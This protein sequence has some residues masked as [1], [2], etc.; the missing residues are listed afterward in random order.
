M[1]TSLDFL[2]R[3]VNVHFGGEGFYLVLTITATVYDDT[4]D[5]PPP[6]PT[7]TLTLPKG[8]TRLDTRTEIS[9]TSTPP[10]DIPVAPKYFIWSSMAP[11]PTQ[12]NW[13]LVIMNN[14]IGGVI[15]ASQF[16]YGGDFGAGWGFI[17]GRESDINNGFSS[18]DD[19]FAQYQADIIAIDPTHIKS[20]TA[21]INT[22]GGLI[23]VGSG[24]SYESNTI[25]E[26]TFDPIHVPGNASTTIVAT[27]LLTSETNDK[28]KTQV[29]ISGLYSPLPT[30]LSASVYRREVLGEITKL[31][32]VT[33]SP[34]ASDGGGGNI[35]RY[36]VT[37]GVDAGTDRATVTVTISDSGGGGGGGGE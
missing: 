33:G 37:A 2:S 30:D 35:D 20:Y 22:S 12:E 19:A 10:H 27:Y 13:D 15:Y 4:T 34:D 7:V 14:N 5:V 6:A 36:D 21:Y 9:T 8:V 29:Q 1:A 32:Q 23:D 25:A 28:A 24:P 26:V 18:Y 31:A 16:W 11:I 17:R 3:I